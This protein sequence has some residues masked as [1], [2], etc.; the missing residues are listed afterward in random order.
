[1]AVDATLP[2]RRRQQRAPPLPLLLLSFPYVLP[3]HSNTT[4]A[5]VQMW[6]PGGHPLREPK[7]VSGMALPSNVAEP[8]ARLS[9]MV[10]VD[11]EDDD[12]ITPSL[13]LFLLAMVTTYVRIHRC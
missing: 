12:C 2:L 3:F 10:M 1:M 6:C 9:M 5:P 7:P 8:R 13:D 4:L 11:V